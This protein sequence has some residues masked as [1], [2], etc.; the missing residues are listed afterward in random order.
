MIDSTVLRGTRLICT[1]ALVL[2][3]LVLFAE[4]TLSELLAGDTSSNL[5][6]QQSYHNGRSAMDALT[7]SLL[8]DDVT[9]PP[10]HMEVKVEGELVF[11][12]VMKTPQRALVVVAGLLVGVVCRDTDRQEPP[13][14]DGVLGALDRVLQFL[15]DRPDHLVEDTLFG[16][17]LAEGTEV[18]GVGIE[19]S[20]LCW[21]KEQQILLLAEGTADPVVGISNN[22]TSDLWLAGQ[23]KVLLGHI[24]DNDWGRGREGLV[25]KLQE[26][27]GKCRRLLSLIEPRLVDQEMDQI[28]QALMGQVLRPELW[29]VDRPL[30]HYALWTNIHYMRRSRF[31]V[32]DAA[33]LSAKDYGELLSSGYPNETVSDHCIFELVTSHGAKTSDRCHVSPECWFLETSGP[34]PSGYPLTSQAALLTDRSTGKSE[35]T[36]C[37]SYRSLDSITLAQSRTF[38]STL[39]HTDPLPDTLIHSLDTLVTPEHVG[40][41]T[42]HS[43]PIPDTLLLSMDMLSPPGHASPLPDTLVHSLDTL[44]HSPDMVTPLPDTMIHSLG[45]LATLGHVGTLTVNAGP[46]PNTLVHSLDT[47]AHSP[48]M[49][50]PLPDTMIHSLGM[51]D[52]LGHTGCEG[53]PFFSDLNQRV[54]DLCSEILFEAETLDLLGVP[55]IVV[56]LF[57]EQGAFTTHPS[58]FQLTLCGIEGFMEFTRPDWLQKIVSLQR[59]PGCYGD[60]EVE[61]RDLARAFS[62]PRIRVKREDGVMEFNCMMHVTGLAAAALATGARSLMKDAPP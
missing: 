9:A 25:D 38:W 12:A 44:A 18:P 14:L 30:R 17:I 48:D 33:A 56:D 60:M 61:E 11:G 16:V 37:S 21:L 59:S 29:L 46:L 1:C 27:C 36:G 62:N 41:L 23:L 26:L 6:D 34:R 45:M 57:L 42:V 24:A 4:A 51:L 2:G 43:G 19:N 5:K 55:P 52:T 50:T 28:H 13:L 47:L 40:T 31:M 3:L 7:S 53:G 58:L 54:E 15:M 10:C 32:H 8:A 22:R 49:V 35:V 39:I 20:R